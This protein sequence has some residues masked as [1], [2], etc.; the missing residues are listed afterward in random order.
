[1]LND[2]R[3]HI[4]N[5][6]EVQE[7]IEKKSAPFIAKTHQQNRAAFARSIPH[8]ITEL[9]AIRSE[10]ISIFCNKNEQYNIVDF[11]LGRTLYGENPD[12]EIQA[13]CENWA[14]HSA[15]LAFS[16]GDNY[17]NSNDDLLGNAL[18]LFQQN[19]SRVLASAENSDVLVLLGLGLGSYIPRLLR[20]IFANKANIKHLIIYEPEAQY[21]K[22]S[23]MVMQWES[24][25]LELEKQ[26]IAIYFQIGKDAQHLI[27]DLQ[28]LQ[29]H[30][31]VSQAIVFQHY[32]HP[33]FD[34]VMHSIRHSD[35]QTLQAKSSSFKAQRKFTQYTPPWLESTKVTELHPVRP[36][37]HRFRDNLL[38]FKKYYPNIY[39]EFSDYQPDTWQAVE[40]KSGSVNLLNLFN[41][42]TWYGNN[43]VEEGAANYRSFEK[44]P[45]KDGLILG[46]NGQKL[47]HYL[48]YRL[49][50]KTEALL[51]QAEDEVNMLPDTIKSLILFGLGAGYE[52][53]SLLEN[54]KLEKLFI[55]EPNRDFF[56][57]SLFAVDWRHILEKLDESEANVY[58]NIGDDGSHLFRDLLG[59]FY[60][61]GP[62]VLSQTF[63]YQSYYN[64]AL[65]SAIAQLREQLQIVVSM[66]EYFDHACFAI[67]HTKEA[68]RQEI[69]FLKS[70]P[71]QY[72]RHENK[73]LPILFVGNGPSLD[74]SIDTI[75]EL[76]G[77]AIVIS[78]GTSLQVLHRNNIVPDFH[79]EIELNR[80]TFDWACR[81]GDPDYLKKITLLSCNGI[82]PDTCVLYKDVLIAFKEGESATVSALN[83]V[84]ED[85]AECLA[86][87][88]PTVSNFAVNL[89]LK[90]GFHQF[91]FFGIDM[92]FV[93]SSQHHS[94]QSGYYNVQGKELY[95][96]AEANNTGLLVPGNFRTLVNTKHEF[97]LAKTII[98][99]ALASTP[100]DCYN[101]S[102]GAL[103]EG[104][105]PLDINNILLMS[106][107]T[108]KQQTLNSLRDCFERSPAKTFVETFD[109][110]Y[111]HSVLIQ[112][113]ESLIDL[114]ENS[115]AMLLG[116][117]GSKQEDIFEFVET[118]KQFLFFSYKQGNSLLFY[119]LYG[120]MNYI[121]SVLS[122]AAMHHDRDI[123]V[124]VASQALVF[125]RDCLCDVKLLL[126]DKHQ[127]F[128]TSSS[129]TLRRERIL[130]AE[131]SLAIEFVSFSQG[132]QD[133]AKGELEKL[134]EFYSLALSF[135]LITD[136]GKETFAS[137]ES[138][139]HYIF[140][141]HDR[142]EWL[143]AQSALTAL[144]SLYRESTK[145]IPVLLCL[146]CEFESEWIKSAE[147]YA[148]YFPALSVS[149]QLLP[150]LAERA[151]ALP[152]SRGE[153]PCAPCSLHVESALKHVQNTAKQFI[154]IEKLDFSEVGLKPAYSEVNN[155]NVGENDGKE[156]AT[157]LRLIPEPISAEF[158]NNQ[159]IS[160][161]RAICAASDF[162]FFDF[163]TYAAVPRDFNSTEAS[164]TVL[165]LA[166]SRGLRVNRPFT[167][168][169]FLLRWQKPALVE[170]NITQYMKAD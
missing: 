110:K 80:A 22:S 61:I 159:I 78:C 49:V 5:D 117:A 36:E 10:S 46:Y 132:L 42:A 120:S 40:N 161:L 45:N 20:E 8:L 2:I 98:E 135:S 109:D 37:Q 71:S 29:T 91:Y 6:D 15:I 93:D 54:K 4:H 105:I 66:G 140:M 77:Q 64:E 158:V 47:K 69:P 68:F 44:H 131:K 162:C 137:T 19:Q 156:A 27:T 154:F 169:E 167:S 73:E 119:Y 23:S 59:Q 50:K 3:V 32:F 157:A 87:A 67:E 30:C 164:A 55:C 53:E 79:A 94:S 26:G 57:G 160:K 85:K 43:P 149:F 126:L 76:Q 100:V 92:G 151:D 14:Q 113:L 83:V 33:T 134:Q 39:A 104:A 58:I 146:A 24:L 51:E 107:E 70:T 155:K 144:N 82:H 125:W 133:I 114:A 38:A 108:Q 102:D 111:Q 86:F 97:K 147:F 88:F 116:E 128:D 168:I 148:K 115:S 143:V 106:S 18:D 56:Y 112:E 142:S 28:E 12:T 62:Y 121:N 11:G 72:L 34:A 96:Y 1:M 170:K 95:K 13:Q 7:Q 122:K 163:K 60:N 124:S 41:G 65:N 138:N 16:D 81:V 84:G 118:Q 141:L 17:D 52:L 35:W 90:L 31:P 165:D 74:Y 99:Q 75:K 129:F 153:V 130:L 63:F 136:V 48:H 9:D 123:A 101:T 152:Y 127:L 150:S 166:G 21:F 139:K 145:Q 89:F 25:L 103:I